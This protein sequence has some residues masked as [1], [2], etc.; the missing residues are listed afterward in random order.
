MPQDEAARSG[1]LSEEDKKRF[2]TLAGV[3]GSVFFILQ[4]VLPMAAMFAIMPVMM[5]GGTVVDFEIS[6]AVVYHGEIHLVETTMSLGGP[7]RSS[8]GSRLVRLGQ[9]TIDEVAPLEGWTPRLL[10]DGDRLWLVSSDRMAV[11]EAGV[12]RPLPL[13]EPLGDTCRP[14]LLEGAPGIVEKKPDGV[15]LLRWEQSAWRQRGLLKGVDDICDIQG[16]DTDEGLLMLRKDGDTLYSTRPEIAESE[17][18]VALSRPERWRLL[19]VDGTPGVVSHGRRGDF[20]I[21]RLEQGRWSQATRAQIPGAA[22]GEFT[23]LQASAGDS[24]SSHRAFQGR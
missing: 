6:D 19:E 17:W 10:A 11:V 18:L 9:E 23:A 1:Y 24:R 2:T 3:L 16:L 22:L 13:A 5:S 15:R 4:V 7:G 12:V 21:A 8:S 14:F 20:R